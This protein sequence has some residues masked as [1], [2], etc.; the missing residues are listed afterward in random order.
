MIGATA[1][2]EDNYLVLL[3]VDGLPT[4]IPSRS[5]VAA[6]GEGLKSFN[7]FGLLGVGDKLYFWSAADR[8]SGGVLLS[9]NFRR[10]GRKLGRLFKLP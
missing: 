5:S 10:R 3:K 8:M 4:V 1:E 7:S 2:V 6:S 9:M